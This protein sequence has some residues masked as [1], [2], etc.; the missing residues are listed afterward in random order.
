MALLGGVLTYDPKKVLVVFG[1][2]TIT[3][4]AEDDMI[5]IAPHG[6]GMQLFVGSDGE[7]ARSVDP[8]HTFEVTLHLATSSKSNE[9]LS[10][11]YNADRQ[12]GMFMLPLLIK[13]L[14]GATLFSA[15]LA[16]VANFPEHNRARTIGTQ[17]WT[18]QT[19]QVI[20][21]IIGGNV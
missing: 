8:D 12:T 11:M 15:A 3:G 6:E 21:P 2:R 18:L 10:Q 5:T 7:V 16:W 20:A 19:G 14:S 4:F 13:D 17:D 1:S 9:Y